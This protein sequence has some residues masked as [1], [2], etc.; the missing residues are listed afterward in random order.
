M[1]MD[2]LKHRIGR[3]LEG[4]VNMAP[5]GDWTMSEAMELVKHVDPKLRAAGFSMG[6]LGSVLIK[7]YST[8]DLDIVVYP[9]SAASNDHDDA[10]KALTVAGMELRCP[11][12]WVTRRWRQTGSQDTKWV[13]VWRWN[14]KRV[15]VFFMQ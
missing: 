5:Q 8:D 9:L 6:V 12:D 1:N 15:D 4:L 2:V 3:W 14:G 10:V 11:R 7:G 13:E